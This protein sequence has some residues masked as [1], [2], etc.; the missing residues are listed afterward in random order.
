MNKTPNP[1]VDFHTHRQIFEINDIAVRNFDLTEPSIL[2]DDSFY[3]VGIHPWK[4][5][6][7][8]AFTNLNLIEGLL[9]NPK[10][11]GIGE[12][13]LDQVNGPE[14]QT[15]QKIFIGQLD[16]AYQNSKPVVL[17]CVKAWDALLSIR[18][19]YS[20][21]IP[22]AVHGFNGNVELAE[23]LIRKGFYISVGESILNKK[24]KVVQAIHKI[25]LN[26]LFIETDVSSF[27]IQTLYLAIAET[28]GLSIDILKHQIHENFKDFFKIY[29]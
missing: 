3:T 11:I 7:E 6:V 9:S 4:A 14:I 5:S 27:T 24:S 17:H 12:I 16:I 22:W 18:K 21:N 8:S 1:F 20:S 25:P 15:Q 29:S 10:V 13:G 23:Q 28:L 2:N 26:R 19:Q